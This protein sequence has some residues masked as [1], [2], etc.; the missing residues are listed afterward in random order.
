MVR[1]TLSLVLLHLWAAV[2]WAEPIPITGRVLDAT[3]LPL[4]EVTVSLV[5]L[6]G[7]YDATLATLDPCREPAASVTTYGGGDGRF[8]IDA[9]ESGPWRL[10]IEAPDRVA[11]ELDLMP[12]VVPT[13]LPPV[14]L[15]RPVWTDVRVVDADGHGIVGAE[16]TTTGDIR[17]DR[18]MLWSYRACATTDEQGRARLPRLET[19]AAN[20][21][22]T[23]VRVGDDA[24]LALDSRVVDE[25]RET[26]EV[27]TLPM[28]TVGF[29][30][31]G[32][33]A[34]GTVIEAPGGSIARLDERGLLV[35][36]E[37]VFEQLARWVVLDDG[38]VT[39]FRDALRPQPSDEGSATIDPVALAPATLDPVTLHLGTP[40]AKPFRGR[41]V[42]TQGAPIADAL[43]WDAEAPEAYTRTNGDGSFSLVMLS[44]GAVSAISATHEGYVL[45]RSSAIGASPL[46]D[47]VLRSES[48]RGARVVA[49]HGRPGAGGRAEIPIVG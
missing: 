42:D 12:L 9:P 14:T 26:V 20:V 49:P 18:A 5:S 34:A 8:R 41:V 37:T 11:L 23:R 33:P 15:H 25:S 35:W 1:S 2:S 24:W 16:V 38:I 32:Q 28:A 3:S 17:A 43:V 45:Y 44:R 36:P 47:I 4:G 39:D 7:R 21:L 29:V 10:R 40:E 27:P 48:T 19:V 13:R 31:A 30:R 22:A 46:P 6:P